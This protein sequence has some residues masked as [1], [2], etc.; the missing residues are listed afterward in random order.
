MVN[1]TIFLQINT[2]YVFRKVY[3][4]FSFPK[5][6]LNNLSKTGNILQFLEKK[7]S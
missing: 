2:F 5:K 7:F 6:Y 1:Y 4:I 3:K